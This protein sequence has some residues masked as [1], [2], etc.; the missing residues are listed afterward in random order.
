MSRKIKAAVLVVL[1][2]GVIIS[3]IVS[4]YRIRKSFSSFDGIV[5]SIPL[6]YI[7][8]FDTTFQKDILANYTELSKVRNPFSILSYQNNYTMFIT[9]MNLDDQNSSISALVN[10]DK[11]KVS[12]SDNVVYTSALKS[13][14]LIRVNTDSMHHVSNLNFTVNTDSIVQTKE[15]DSLL[16]LYANTNNFSIKYD[17]KTPVDIIGT[18]D[19]ILGYN[20]RTLNFIFLKKNKALYF[21]FMVP[22]EPTAKIPPDLLCHLIGY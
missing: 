1:G 13:P 7:A 21:L 11:G 22:D 6:D 14:M 3:V 12:Q 15:N 16:C 5:N 18:T 17:K 19:G 20:K 10:L 2:I 8:L 9:K 4:A